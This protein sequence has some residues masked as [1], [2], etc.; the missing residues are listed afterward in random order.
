[1][2][3]SVFNYVKFWVCILCFML[4]MFVMLYWIEMMKWNVVVVDIRV[5]GFLMI[6][7]NV[8]GNLEILVFC[9]EFWI[10]GLIVLGLW[11]LC[12][13]LFLGEVYYSCDNWVLFFVIGEMLWMCGCGLC[14]M[15]DN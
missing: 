2:C 1:M 13:D 4:N 10:C 3:F 8:W 9:F 5:C 15:V 7:L 14:G 12:V 6:I 11:V